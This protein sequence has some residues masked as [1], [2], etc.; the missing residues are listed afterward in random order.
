MTVM[1]RP[2]LSRSELIAAV[3]FTEGV[4]DRTFRRLQAEGRITR[5]VSMRPRA[6][7]RAQGTVVLF[8]TLN[9]DAL[10]LHR[11]GRHDEA[12]RVVAQAE[13]LESFV[14]Q[15]VHRDTE[16]R[17]A[18]HLGLSPDDPVRSF[19]HHWP[20]EIVELAT[21]TLSA[22]QEHHRLFRELGVEQF[23]GTVRTLHETVALVT[24]DDSSRVLVPRS[25][26]QRAD[27][28]FEGAPVHVRWEALF[29]GRLLL[30]EQA[31]PDESGAA[32]ATYEADDEDPPKLVRLARAPLTA[33]AEDRLS[34]LLS[35]DSRI[36]IVAPLP[37][38]VR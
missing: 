17:W 16:G 2:L 38:P 5:G 35:S 1:E 11:R 29:H 13:T 21:R 20:D 3:D 26:L 30:V 34:Q 9:R 7:G 32:G 8:S 23:S 33:Q 31:L 25:D 14:E 36:G 15:I 28:D 22:R 6:G 18:E 12:R 19:A 10:S 27:S 37:V 24:R 4:S